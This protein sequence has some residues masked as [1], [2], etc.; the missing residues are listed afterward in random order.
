VLARASGPEMAPDRPRRRSDS[1]WTLRGTFEAHR[2]NC[3]HLLPV[4][5]ATRELGAWLR[6]LGRTTISRTPRPSSASRSQSL[7]PRA[8]RSP[9]SPHPRSD[10]RPTPTPQPPDSD[11]GRGRRR[12]TQ[13]IV[14]AWTPSLEAP[15]ERGFGGVAGGL[16]WPAKGRRI[17]AGLR[18]CASEGAMRRCVGAWVCSR[19]GAVRGSAK[20]ESKRVGVS[21]LAASLSLSFLRTH[22]N[23]ARAGSRTLNLGI[24]SPE[25]VIDSRE[26]S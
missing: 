15:A 14:G 24:K 19:W 2:R 13:R 1:N 9:A 20:C 6:E 4:L 22:T 25:V 23:G 17:G 26:D 18:S 3:E 12:G 16:S 7:P 8:A 10:E 11:L 21:V 5:N